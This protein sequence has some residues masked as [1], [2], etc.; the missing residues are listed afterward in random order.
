MNSKML[1]IRSSRKPFAKSGC[2]VSFS[3]GF[4][5]SFGEIESESKKIESRK[6]NK[7]ERGIRKKKD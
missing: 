4:G 5:L 6:A 1:L 3:R 7:K 2:R